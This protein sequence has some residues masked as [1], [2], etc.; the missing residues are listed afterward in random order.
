MKISVIIPVHELDERT[1]KYLDNALLSIANQ[2]VKPSEVLIVS[3]GVDMSKLSNLDKIKDIVKE[4][5]NE[6]NT[7][8]CS[9]VNYGVDQA[10]GDYISILEL[11]DEYSKLVFGHRLLP[12][13]CI[14]EHDPPERNQQYAATA[15]GFF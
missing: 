4:V 13:H 11:D 10:S 15:S 9:Q 7:D 6:G 1:T 14:R 8:F 5:K 12:R 2:V 3:P